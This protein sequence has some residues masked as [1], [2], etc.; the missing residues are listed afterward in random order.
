MSCNVLFLRSSCSSQ[1]SLPPYLA[2]SFHPHLSSSCFVRVQEMHLPERYAAHPSL[3]RKKAVS[4]SVS[5][6]HPHLLCFEGEEERCWLPEAD[7][8]SLN[9]SSWLPVVLSPVLYHS[10]T[11]LHKDVQMGWDTYARTNIRHFH[12]H[13]GRPVPVPSHFLQYTQLV[14]N[15]SVW[16]YMCC[17]V[18]MLLSHSQMQKKTDIFS[19]LQDL[20]LKSSFAF[21]DGGFPP[22]CFPHSL[23]IRRRLMRTQHRLVYLTAFLP[24]LSIKQLR[25]WQWLDNPSTL[26]VKTET[27]TP[28]IKYNCANTYKD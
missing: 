28:P 20:K 11:P 6:P 18:L 21:C 2:T 3:S 17:S 26:P 13:S 4:L 8:S 19:F 27:K 15:P 16:A 9:N 12:Q 7:C 25:I 23:S 22:F 1:R 24:L 5:P 14:K 10:I